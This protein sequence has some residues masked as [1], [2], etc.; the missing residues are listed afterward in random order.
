M[1]TFREKVIQLT[2]PI[3][4]RTILVGL[5]GQ[6]IHTLTGHPN[7]VL[8]VEAADVIV[9][10]TKSPDGRPVPI[11]WVQNAL[12]RLVRDGEIEISV[13]SVGYR[14]ALI[15]AVLATLPG[16]TTSLRPAVI[17]LDRTA[18]IPLKGHDG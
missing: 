2:A 9:A 10:T 13:E 16:V 1:V 7:R 17:R 12:D 15:G 6:L 3:D 8:R 11:S 5:I 4:A 18:S 14:S